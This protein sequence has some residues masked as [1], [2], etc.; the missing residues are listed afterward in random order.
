MAGEP[1]TTAAPLAISSSS[2]T[3]MSD[4]SMLG[5][6]TLR[7]SAMMP[8]T[9][10]SGKY[11]VTTEFSRLSAAFSTASTRRE[12]CCSYSAPISSPM[13]RVSAPTG[14]V[15]PKSSESF[16]SMTSVFTY[17]MV[18]SS[19][20]VLVIALATRNR[21][22]RSSCRAEAERLTVATSPLTST[23]FAP[24]SDSFTSP[25]SGE[26]TA[27]PGCSSRSRTMLSAVSLP[28]DSIM[29]LFTAIRRAPSC[30]G[31]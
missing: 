4:G 14:S 17:W 27:L 9:A 6:A 22:C 1:L 24:Y 13:L 8:L 3:A 29:V 18:P 5:K 11:S 25:P 28:S 7:A 10:D 30:R 19:V 20:S 15:E 31:R 12:S 2:F 16:L 26:A 23:G 21:P